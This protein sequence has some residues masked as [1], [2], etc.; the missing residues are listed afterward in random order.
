MVNGQTLRDLKG[1]LWTIARIQGQTLADPSS[2]AFV[3]YAFESGVRGGE[4]ASWAVRAG[5]C[6]Q[7]T[8]GRMLPRRRN[9]VGAGLLLRGTLAMWLV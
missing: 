8:L 5:T 2:V 1:H 4:E 9:K 7:S 6:C 3:Q